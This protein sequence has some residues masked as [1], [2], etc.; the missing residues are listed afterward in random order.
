MSSVHYY[1]LVR[2]TPI[3]AALQGMSLQSCLPLGDRY[4]FFL[5]HP[6]PLHVG[7]LLSLRDI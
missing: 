5:S 1:M 4:A 7:R 2:T 6:S 3:M